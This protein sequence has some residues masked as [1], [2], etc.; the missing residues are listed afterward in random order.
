[1]RE[2]KDWEHP[3]PWF[4]VSVASTGFSFPVSRLESMLTDAFVTV[5]SKRFKF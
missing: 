4:F 3:P 1:V 2:V 5:D